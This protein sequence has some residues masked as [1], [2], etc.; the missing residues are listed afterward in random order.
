MSSIAESSAV[1]A[2]GH[3]GIKPPWFSLLISAA[4]V[5]LFLLF[6][7]AP[8]SLIFDR[9]AVGQGEWWRLIT[10][11]LVHS[12]I[13]HALWDI[14]AFTMI[15]ALLEQFD[16]KG[17]VLTVLFSMLTISGWIWW[18]MPDLIRYAGLSGIINALFPLLLYRLWQ[19]K[20]QPIVLIIAAAAGLKLTLEVFTGQALFTD[21]LWPSVPSVHLIGVITAMLFILSVTYTQHICKS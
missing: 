13:S 7:P 16:R 1:V 4:A 12:D 15:S 17:L 21:T 14:M 5:G 19:H 20:P 6:G 2:D 8:E 3:G 11:H 10:G 9:E 18:G